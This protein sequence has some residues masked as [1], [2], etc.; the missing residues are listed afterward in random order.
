MRNWRVI[1]AVVAVLVLGVALPY[2]VS[3]YYLAIVTQV[4][5][6]GL[7]AMSIDLLGGYT[8]LMPLGHAGVMG[9]P[10]TRSGF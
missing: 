4:L 9:W 2:L 1:G 6:F 3:S 5:F 7:L 10:A 8:G